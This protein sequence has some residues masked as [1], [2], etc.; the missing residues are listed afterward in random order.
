MCQRLCL[1][2]AWKKFRCIDHDMAVR[3]ALCRSHDFEES[4]SGCELMH[5]QT[6]F[7]H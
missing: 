2:V 3:C 6:E 1:E 7:W 5:V 4:L